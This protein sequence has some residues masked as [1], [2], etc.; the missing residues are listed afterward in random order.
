VADTSLLGAERSSLH[1]HVPG[2]RTPVSM[3]CAVRN[4]DFRLVGSIGLRQEPLNF[5][6]LV[7]GKIY[8]LDRY[9]GGLTAGGSFLSDTNRDGCHVNM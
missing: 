5:D 8:F 4:E 1:Y 7:S 3:T 9:C 2:L 6:Y